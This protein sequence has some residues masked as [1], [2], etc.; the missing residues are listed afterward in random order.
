MATEGFYYPFDFGA[1]R[2]N[3]GMTCPKHG[4]QDGGPLVKVQPRHDQP[5]LIK[6]YCG[7]CVLE[8]FDQFCHRETSDV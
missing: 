1:W 8:L 5:P 2:L 3:S 7:Q 4:F 6:R